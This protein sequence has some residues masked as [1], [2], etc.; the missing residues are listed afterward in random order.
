MRGI[1][2]D[3]DDAAV[4]SVGRYRY[5]QREKGLHLIG[6]RVAERCTY[7]LASSSLSVLGLKRGPVES[8]GVIRSTRNVRQS[9]RAT[10]Q[11]SR[12]QRRPQTTSRSGSAVR[13]VWLP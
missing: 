5:C 13:T 3:L 1:R 10:S 2:T 7:A 12:Y 6:W 8:L 9:S 4:C 11:A